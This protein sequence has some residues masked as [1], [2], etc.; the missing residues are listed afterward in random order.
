MALDDIVLPGSRSGHRPVQLITPVPGLVVKTKDVKG[1]KIFI[2]LVMHDIVKMP[3]DVNM[4]EVAREHIAERG[5]SNLRVPLDVSDPRDTEDKR[6]DKATAID[7]MF[8]TFLLDRAMHGQGEIEG[9]PTRIYFQQE[10]AS[11]A[12]KDVEDVLKVG[13]DRNNFKILKCNYKGGAKPEPFPYVEGAWDKQQESSKASTR[14]RAT[15]ASEGLTGPLSSNPPPIKKD[16]I[17][18]SEAIDADE[19]CAVSTTRKKPSNVVKKGFLM[20][21]GAGKLYKNDDGTYGSNEQAGAIDSSEQMRQQQLAHLP[22]SLRKK[23]AI[24]DTTKMSKDEIQDAMSQYANTG[25]VLSGPAAPGGSARNDPQYER[26]FAKLYKKAEAEAP[27]PTF[28]LGGLRFEHRN[29]EE[30]EGEGEG[31]EEGEEEEE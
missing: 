9:V 30:G 27:E 22:E 6:G 2:N 16:D 1:K 5:L 19:I 29:D 23:C 15:G 10:L 8:N 12:I 13:I 7:V 18:I 21:D 4:C 31:E 17:A 26:E 24:V 3:V 20:G 11:L 14:K 25:R 28:A